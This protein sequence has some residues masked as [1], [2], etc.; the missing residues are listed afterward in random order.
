[1]TSRFTL[2]KRASHI[3][4]R[5]KDNRLAP[6]NQYASDYYLVEFPK[7]GVTWL[8]VLIANMLGC[9]DE[10]SDHATFSS[11]GRYVHDLHLGRNVQA[12]PIGRSQIRLYKSHGL[13]NRNYR[14]VIYIARHPAD[15]LSSYFHFTMSLQKNNMTL[16]EFCATPT[17]GIEAWRNHV[18]SWL[19]NS[20]NSNSYILHLIRYEDLITKPTTELRNLCKNFGWN[21]PDE[22]IGNAVALAQRQSMTEQENLYRAHNPNH[23][24]TFVRKEQRQAMNAKLRQHIVDQ[25]RDEL[26]LL[27]YEN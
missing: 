14:K 6:I 22:R 1:M 9:E 23:G 20:L 2:L 11:I 15:V 25:T 27:G 4:R 5:W 18:R 13:C 12:E 16:E 10:T 19:S 8:S 3:K 21:V 7:S 17:L 24:M 26:T